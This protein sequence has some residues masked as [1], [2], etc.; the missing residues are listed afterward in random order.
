M[1]FNMNLQG[2][3]HV[4]LCISEHKYRIFNTE[5][6][7]LVHNFNTNRQCPTGKVFQYLVGSEKIPGSGS[8][9]GRVGV[10]K[11]I[12]GYFL[13]IFFIIRYFWVFLRIS[14]YTWVFL[15]ILYIIF[16]WR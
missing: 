7:G 1:V 15:G 8:G 13:G 2:I 11:Y 12:T 3:K 6:I 16:F 4:V 9:S 14:G 5:S 10:L